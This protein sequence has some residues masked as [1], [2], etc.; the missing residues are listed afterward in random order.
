MSNVLE[1]L[2]AERRD[3]RVAGD[4]LDLAA[5]ARE[6]LGQRGADEVALAVV[7]DDAAGARRALPVQHDLLGRQDVRRRPP[8]RPGIGARVKPLRPSVA[9]LRAGRQHD[10]RL[11]RRAAISA[12]LSS[13]SLTSSTFGSRLSAAIR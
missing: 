10:T 2:G 4:E 13:R 9:Q 8:R 12:P 7:D 3:R 1:R 11:P 6:Q 5:L